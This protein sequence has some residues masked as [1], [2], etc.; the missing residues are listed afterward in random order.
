MLKKRKMKHF[1]LKK[2][3]F[4]LLMQKMPLFLHK[5]RDDILGVIVPNFPLYH[6]NLP[7]IQRI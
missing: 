2:R 3:Q 6:F 7:D 1:F 5:F 4:L